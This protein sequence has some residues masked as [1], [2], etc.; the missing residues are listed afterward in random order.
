MLGKY[1]EICALR[2]QRGS[3]RMRRAGPT[4]LAGNA[5]ANDWV[6]AEF[7]WRLT[8]AIGQRIT[9]ESLVERRICKGMILKN[10]E[11]LGK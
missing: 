4:S 11:K 3:E 9:V 6:F 5:F 10:I 2:R 7:G 1:G 8:H